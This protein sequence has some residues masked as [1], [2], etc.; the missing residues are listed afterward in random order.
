MGFFMMLDVPFHIQATKFDCGP[1]ALQMSLEYL[2][3]KPY[4]RAELQNLVDS[5]RSGVTWTLGLAKSAAQL[6]FR[7]E[8]YSTCLG[9]NP[10]NFDLD[11]YKRMSGEAGSTEQKLEKLKAEAVS[12]GVN[13]EER[14]L[15]LE[16]ILAKISPSCVSIVLLDWGKIMNTSKYQGHFVPIVG[17][18]DQNV[19]IHNPAEP[20]VKNMPIKRE[21]FDEARKSTGT[22]EDMVFIYKKR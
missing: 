4:S 19:Y 1:T 18:D 17:Y 10:R 14:S 22:D 7:T 5:E 21:L 6:G 9:F 20:P 15:S 16:E 8:F 11:F 3:S 2:E 12:Y 13:M